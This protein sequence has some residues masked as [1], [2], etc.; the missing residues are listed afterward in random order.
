MTNQTIERLK[1]E[2]QTNQAA[3]AMFHVLATRERARSTITL[4]ALSRKMKKEGFD[5]PNTAY[6]A[7]LSLLAQLGLGQLLTDARGRTKA[8]KSITVSLPSLGRAICDKGAMAKVKQFR[9]RPRFISLMP[10]PAPIK[11]EEQMARGLTLI[12]PVAGSRT[13]NLPIP[14]GMSPE[15]LA[16]LVARFQEKR[17]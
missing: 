15:D 7:I 1:Q 12:V 13:V 11:K 8:L 10:A 3:N 5:Y 2:A 6:V 16:L 4:R 14:E 9:A 17:A